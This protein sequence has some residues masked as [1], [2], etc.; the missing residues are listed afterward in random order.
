MRRALLVLVAGG[1]QF[2]A[3]TGAGGDARAEA[4]AD[5]TIPAGWWDP[6]WKHRR[7]IT[8]DNSTVTADLVGF[9]VPIGLAQTDNANALGATSTDVRF[10]A[11][12][13][14]TVLPYDVDTAT[15][16]GATFWV[17]IAIPAAPAAKPTLWVYFGDTT[18]AGDASNAAAVWGSFV[19]VHHLGDLHDATGN[20]HDGIPGAAATVPAPTQGVIG[21][22]AQFDGTD[23]AIPLATTAAYD[24]TTSLSVSVWFRLQSFTSQWECFVCK[25][26]TAWRLHRGN[27]SSHPSFG[28]TEQAGGTDDLNASPNGD[29]GTWH[30]FAVESDGTNKLSYV[31][32]GAPTM[33][34]P[35]KLATN[36]Q[37]VVVGRN[38]EAVNP[39][40]RYFAG[41]LDELRIGGTVRGRTWY[42]AE[43][44]AG[45]DPTFVGLGAI[46]TI[47]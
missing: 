43:Y 10:I 3:N 16:D 13:N 18:N 22:G 30:L 27:F 1:C 38:V 4:G 39:S 25:G 40:D 7:A 24:L 29:D 19:S 32:G 26:D 6:A 45:T 35:G 14:T 8:I 31:D 46:E 36:A 21:L 9:P 37:Q 17:P 33:S 20:H 28:T 15:A 42:A 11:A 5:A 44:R 34:S 23:D 12:D 47:R 2:R 41:T